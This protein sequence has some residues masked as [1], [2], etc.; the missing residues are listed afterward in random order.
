VAVRLYVPKPWAQAPKRRQQ[1]RLPAEVAFQTK[2]DIAL[3]LLDQ[4]RA[5][6]VPPRGVVAEAD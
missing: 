1:A 4:A 6:G 2:P 5:W 3:T